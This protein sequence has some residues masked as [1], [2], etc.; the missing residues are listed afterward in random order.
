[1]SA[2]FLKPLARLSAR[3]IY[4]S[5]DLLQFKLSRYGIDFEFYYE[6]YESEEICDKF[7]HI[8]S[9]TAWQARQSVQCVVGNLVGATMFGAILTS[10]STAASRSRRCRQ[11]SESTL[12]QFCPLL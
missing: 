11:A 9:S 3:E 6:V 7:P 5:A 1:M 2:H 10:G 4:I 8:G 12:L